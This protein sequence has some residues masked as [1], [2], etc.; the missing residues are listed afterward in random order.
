MLEP[1]SQILSPVLKEIKFKEKLD[2]KWNKRSGTLGQDTT[3]LIPKPVKE[4]S[5]K[6]FL[7]LDHQ[8]VKAY[9][10]II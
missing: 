4:I 5:L 3:Q 6:D 8:Q 10:N 9:V 2:T 7:S 1:R